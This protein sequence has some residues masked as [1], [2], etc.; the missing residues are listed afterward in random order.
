MFGLITFPG[1]GPSRPHS[2]IIRLPGSQKYGNV[3]LQHI[4]IVNHLNIDGTVPLNCYSKV[5]RGSMEMGNGGERG[6]KRAAEEELE[7]S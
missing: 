1:G 6:A 3:F 5:A 2:A 7:T 4:K